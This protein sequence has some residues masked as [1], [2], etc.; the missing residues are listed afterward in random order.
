MRAAIREPWSSG[1]VEGQVNRLKTLKRQ[2]PDGEG[3]DLVALEGV[4][5][6]FH[7]LR[8]GAQGL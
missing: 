2:M 7:Q 8:A 5:P 4:M 1:Q 3:D 6:C